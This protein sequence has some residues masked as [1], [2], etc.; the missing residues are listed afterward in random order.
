LSLLDD[1]YLPTDSTAFYPKGIP[2]LSFFTGS[3]EDYNRP[4]DDPDT[5]DY[6][7]MR[8]IAA[9]G[10]AIVNDIVSNDVRPDYAEVQVT[11]NAGG[12]RDSLRAYLG[13][14]PD[15]TTDLPGVAISGVRGGGP[16]DK[17]G[18]QGG[19]VIVAFAGQTITNIYDYTYS[20]DAIKIGEPVDVV[21][22]RDGERTTLRI[23]PEARP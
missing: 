11:T 21:V 20:L 5:L 8:R 12:S 16:A 23:V 3:H 19:D 18:M 2:I 9:F 6:T 13:T 10:A 4:S 22:L 1:P 15:Y 7:G 17:A 14:I